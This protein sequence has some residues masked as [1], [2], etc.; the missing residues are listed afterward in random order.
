MPLPW[1]RLDSSFAAH[2]KVLTLI[3]EHGERGR[4]ALFVYVCGL[5]Y[6]GQ[7]ETDGAIPFAAMPF[8]HG[9]RRDAELLVQAVLWKPTPT[10][11]EVVN[12]LKRQRAAE[13]SAAVRVARRSAASKGNCVRWHGTDC[14]CWKGDLS[15]V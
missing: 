14:N 12:W 7:Q 3:H 2:D 11:Y 4:S 13:V 15:A 9:R 1:V 6:C 5:A 10:G 8:I